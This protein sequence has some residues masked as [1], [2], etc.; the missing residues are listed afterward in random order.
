MNVVSFSLCLNELDKYFFLTKGKNTG[1]NLQVA[2]E[3]SRHAI[4]I[5][6]VRL[7]A[8]KVNNAHNIHFF[9]KC[10]QRAES[11]QSPEDLVRRAGA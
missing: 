3:F 8:V 10:D 4:S 1:G 11:L 6:S 5:W 9:R 2:W 7:L